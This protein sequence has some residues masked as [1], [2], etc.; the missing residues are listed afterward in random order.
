MR[1]T[2]FFIPT[3]KEIPADAVV[4][5]HTLMIRAGLI[6]Q[7]VAGAYTY[8]PLGY[9]VL[10][11]AAQIV[12]EEMNR[13]GAIELHMPAMQPVE[14]WKETGRVEAMGDTLIH[15]PDQDWRSGTVL[16]PT[17]EEVITDI[18]RAFVNSYKQL[19]INLYQIQTKFRDEKRPKSGVLRT[20]EFLMKDAY[21]FDVDLD[22]LNASYD[23]MYAAYCR[24]YERCGLPYVSVEADS[25]AIGGDVSHEFMVATDAG[26]D[27]LVKTADGSYAANV[28]RAEV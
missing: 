28:E 18:V 4:P 20:R 8:L 22:G 16:G 6:K 21:S 1:W 13:A 14:L 7:L 24:I 25:G 19:P 26:E 9:R 2:E 15:L 3:S 23:K 10:R 11:K 27:I 17:H 5:S 12:R